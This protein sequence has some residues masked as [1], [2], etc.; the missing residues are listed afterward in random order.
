MS[1]KI[2]N[3]DHS[4]VC[5]ALALIEIPGA[6]ASSTTMPLDK[7]FDVEL[8]LIKRFRLTFSP[9]ELHADVAVNMMLEFREL[10]RKFGIGSADFHHIATASAEGCSLFVTT[11][12]RHLLRQKCKDELKK[13]VRICS[14]AEALVEIE[15][16]DLDRRGSRRPYGS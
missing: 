12:E 5:S 7:I 2:V 3:G 4:G 1:A 9:F 13:Y 11:D 15:R 8:S 10:K 14:P 6:L 16:E